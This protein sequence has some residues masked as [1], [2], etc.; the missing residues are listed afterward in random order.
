M[1]DGTMTIGERAA[2]ASATTVLVGGALVLGMLGIG[3]VAAD[4][5]KQ[6]GERLIEIVAPHLP[7]SPS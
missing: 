1:K 6:A 7:L 5:G 2:S 3:L 4:L